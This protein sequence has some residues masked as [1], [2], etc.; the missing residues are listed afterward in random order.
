MTAVA[1]RH[2]RRDR[3]FYSP[4]E[5][6]REELAA[7]ATKISPADPV[8]LGIVRGVQILKDTHFAT[9]QSCQGGE[10]HAFPEPTILFQATRAGAFHALSVLMT[11]ELPVTELGQV[12]R[13]EDGV[14]TGPAWVVKFSRPLD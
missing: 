9:L 4:L 13:M 1:E 12:W 8:D 6:S 2:T 14:P 7:F 5:W 10:G 11:Y 3:S